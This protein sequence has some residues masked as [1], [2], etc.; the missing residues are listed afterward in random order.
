MAPW[1]QPDN[2]Q[3]QRFMSHRLPLWMRWYRA[4]QHE[5]RAAWRAQGLAA[6]RPLALDPRGLPG[7]AAVLRLGARGNSDS[8]R[9]LAAAGLARIVA[10]PRLG[11][12]GRRW[13][14]RWAAAEG[15][16]VADA[17]AP[18]RPPPLA[19][20]QAVAGRGLAIPTRDR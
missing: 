18:D 1:A 8:D 14:L 4:H 13:M 16:A 3:L 7:I 9:A 5:D 12:V 19:P 11:A 2:Q 17:G 15:L 10:S 20:S 6:A